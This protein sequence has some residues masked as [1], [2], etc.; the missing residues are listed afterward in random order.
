[1]ASCVKG[2]NMALTEIREL[3]KGSF[4]RVY[5]AQD[6][7]LGEVA[8]KELLEPDF[9]KERFRREV[10][11]LVD[12]SQ[13][14]FVVDI[15]R[16]DL[17]APKP[18]M[19]LEYCSGGSLRRWV[20][21][22]AWEHAAKV[23]HHAASGLLAIHTAGGFHRD[24]KPENLLVSF[25]TNGEAT[26]KVADFG[27]ARRPKTALPPMTARAGGTPGYIAPELKNPAENFSAA[28]DIY[29]LGV[30]GIELMTGDNDPASVVQSNAP[31][32]FKNLLMRMT[33]DWAVI[34]PSTA[35]TIIE[36]ER[37]LQIQR[38]APA[39]PAVVPR[40]S[41]AQAVGAGL[42]GV[43]V[44]GGIAAIAAALMVGNKPQY[45]PVVDRYRGADGRFKGR[46]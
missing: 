41:P 28:C 19:I 33:S 11:M 34:R 46:R 10:A 32:D 9:E 5:L 21:K 36:L 29:S 35:D 44:V 18:Y 13:N 23:L 7:D 37:I 3:G 2:R 12:Q 17:N 43:L 6:D 27:L 38:P 4:G 14:P 25:T 26:I 16:Y 24:I 30:V 8:V 42:I 45:D 15:Y 40:M 1:M 31:E 20:A 22:F 39:P